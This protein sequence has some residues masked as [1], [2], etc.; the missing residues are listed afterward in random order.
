MCTIFTIFTNH[1]QCGYKM[2]TIFT[3]HSQCWYKMCIIFTNHSQCGYKM[4]TIFTN[5]SQCGYKSQYEMNI[6]NHSWWWLHDMPTVL[7]WRSQMGNADRGRCSCKQSP[8]VSL[9]LTSSISFTEKQACYS[10]LTHAYCTH[11]NCTE[12]INIR[13]S[14]YPNKTGGH[15][16]L[17]AQNDDQQG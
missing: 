5:H 11:R 12:Q 2:C 4:C 1:S 6:L 3:N 15:F 14:T 17:S 7:F 10:R 8:L 13:L 16:K 9:T